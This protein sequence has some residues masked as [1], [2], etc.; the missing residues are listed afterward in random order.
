MTTLEPGASE[1]LTQ[2]LRPRPCSR[3]FSPAARRQHNAGVGGV[4]AAGDGSN[5]DIP[6]MQTERLPMQADVLAVFGLLPCS[7]SSLFMVLLLAL[8]RRGLG[9]VWG[10]QG[11][12]QL[13]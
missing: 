5:D 13:G 12:V 10:L 3:A 4:G 6:L 11:W 1:V 7:V 9:G 2:G 8:G